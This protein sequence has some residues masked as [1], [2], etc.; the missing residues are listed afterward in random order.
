MAFEN[1]GATI[2]SPL[3]RASVNQ[4]PMSV[5]QWFHHLISQKSFCPKIFSKP[6]SASCR[7]ELWQ[8]SR[9]SLRFHPNACASRL[10]KTTNRQPPT[11]NCLR[12]TPSIFCQTDRA[13]A[14]GCLHLRNK[15]KLVGI[16]QDQSQRCSRS[17]LEELTASLAFLLDRLA[18]KYPLEQC[19]DETVIARFV[20]IDDFV[21]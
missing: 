13:P 9:G 10:T 11:L 16:E 17:M 4:F 14:Q 12:F 6:S 3:P 15:R 1:F 20:N 7:V 5:H 21:R 18:R 19:D 8:T 2:C